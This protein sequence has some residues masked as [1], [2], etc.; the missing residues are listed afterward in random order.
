MQRI[1]GTLIFSPS[2]LQKF[3]DCEHLTRLQL[4]VCEG[5]LTVPAKDDEELELLRRKGMQHERAWLERLRSEGKS[6]VEIPDCND[7]TAAAIATEAAMRSG[8]DVIYQAV[9]QHDAWRGIADFLVRVPQ[10]TAFGPWGY[11]AWDTK[12]ARRGKPSY[13]LQL[14]FYCEQIERV[15]GMPPELMHVVLGT[16][17]EQPYRPRDFAAYFRRLK[18]RLQAFVANGAPSA[19]YPVPHCSQCDFENVCDEGWDTVDHL[20]RIASIRREQVE[21]LEAFGIRT[22]EALGTAQ[23]PIPVKIGAATL[24]SLIGQARLQN[25]RRI[26]GTH[27]YELLPPEQERGFSL[28]P[29]SDQGD[30]FFDIEGYPHFEPR[31]GLE[32]LFGIVGLERGIPQFRAFWAKDRQAEKEMFEN[33]IDFVR[34][35]LARRPKLHVYHYAAYEPTKLKELMQRHGTREEEV[36]DL[37][38]RQVFIDLF[39]V[40]RQT[41]RTSHDGY[42]LKQIRTFFMKGVGEGLVTG[43]G[44]SILEFAR[45]LETRDGAILEAIERYN[46]EDCHSTLQLREWLLQRKGEAEQQFQKAIPWRPQPAEADEPIEQPVDVDAGV[47]GRLL[48]MLSGEASADLLSNLLGYHRREAKPEWWAYYDRLQASSEELLQNTEAIARLSPIESRPPRKDKQSVIHAFSFP[49]QEYKLAVGQDVTD[50]QAGKGAGVIVT[51]DGSAGILELKRGPSLAAV[52]LPT[53]II[54]GKPLP[55][56]TQAAAVARYVEDVAANGLQASG[57]RSISA[58]IQRA[59]PRFTN[60]AAGS[61]QTLDLAEQEALVADLDGSCLFIQGPPGS[62]KTWTGARLIVSLLVKGCRIGVAAQSHKAIHNLLEEV[63]HVAIEQGVSFDGLKKGN[64]P[65]SEFDGQFIRSTNSNQECEAATAQLVAGTSWL[66][67]REGMQQSLDYLFIDEAGQTSLGDAVAMGM[68][69]RNLVLLGDPQQLANVSQGV[70]AAGSGVSVLEHLLGDGAT[71]DERNGLFL[72]RSWRMHPDV[73]RFVSELSYEGRLES[74]PDRQRQRIESSGLNGTGLRFV[75]V[76]HSGNA[77]RSPEEAAVIAEE[78]ARLLRDGRYVDC[79]GVAHPLEPKDILVVAPYNMQVRC[80]LE[81]L[82][83]GVEAGTVDKFQGRE[84]P[85]VFFSLA[86]SSGDNVPRD[87][88]FLFSRNRLNVAISRAKALAVLVA[89]PRLLEVGCRTVEQM[90][91]VN[92]WCR[93]VE[94]AEDVAGIAK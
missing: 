58:L 62:G 26:T 6:I 66:F 46:E 94:L 4:R 89:S 41:M 82:P 36:D 61:I 5:E 75:P 51:L 48:R 45:W 11:E 3:V 67:A 53:A 91:L 32:Y 2:D 92:G 40:V 16:N 10:L 13:V 21:K 47:R 15:Q 57:F 86:T 69:A 60:R 52:P 80:L 71:V 33:F 78:V 79:D 1:D 73:C 85:I 19:P 64:S 63:E 34:E 8:I 43:G 74:A 50:P 72:A 84:A 12:L 83:A 42:S 56:D 31:A 88:T 25:E 7:W 38:R 54:S 17:E 28:L 39:R 81:H 24:V 22:L 77:Q 59:A 20:S 90:R 44:Q 87:L 70:H 23:P 68:S 14:M 93:F 55:T 30:L 49:E 29:E 9:F 18:Q 76:A 35:R 37:L 65:E 27:S